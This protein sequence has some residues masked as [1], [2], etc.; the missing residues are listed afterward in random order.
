MILDG[1]YP[2]TVEYAG[3]IKATD[4]I[5]SLG[6][7]DPALTAAYQIGWAAWENVPSQV[8]VSKYLYTGGNMIFEDVTRP[9]NVDILLLSGTSTSLTPSFYYPSGLRYTSTWGTWYGPNLS[10]SLMRFINQ[11]DVNTMLYRSVFLLFLVGQNDA[12]SDVV[13]QYITPAQIAAGEV[14]FTL[15]YGGA[16]IPVTQDDI[17]G[18]LKIVE[19]DG[20]T[21]KFACIEFG[22]DSGERPI[23]PDGN[24]GNFYAPITSFMLHDTAGNSFLMGGARP[25]PLYGGD[26]S[27]AGYRLYADTGQLHY[28]SN[29][30]V[31]TDIGSNRYIWGGFRGTMPLQD[32]QDMP[33]YGM[34]YTEG[35]NFFVSCHGRKDVCMVRR[36][37]VWDDICKWASMQMRYG[38]T[39]AY[40]T[41]SDKYYAKISSDNEFLG[42]LAN[43]EI[44]FADLRPW[45]IAGVTLD[46]TSN[47]YTPDQKPPY[48]E[49]DDEK[50]GD[51]IG[52]NVNV[53]G[54][55]AT[56]LYTMYALRQAHVSNLGAAL[57]SS[58]NDPDG[59]FW[60]NL[61][62]AF[63]AYTET[64]SADISSV[65]EYITA[66]RIYPFAL[67][68]LPG[69]AG[70]GTGAIKIGSGKTDLNLSTGG[71]GNVGIMGSYTGI[72]DA[73]SVTIPAHYG[74]FRDYDGVSMSVY[75]PYIG[76]V[77]L[78]AA[79]V[80]GQTLQAT[81]AVD[82]TTGTAVCYLLLSGSWGYYPIGIYHGTIGAD[83]PLTAAQ[84]NRLFTRQLS[85][86]IS[87]I[88]GLAA[89][90]VIPD[91]VGAGISAISR[92]QS[93]ANA[94]TASALTPPT[95]G[96]G[97]ANFA[98][99]GAPQTAYVQ[100]RRHLYAYN[101]QTFPASQLGRRSYGVHTLGT[102]SGFTICDAVD[103]SGIPAPADIQTGIKNALESGVYL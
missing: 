28:N 98:G 27:G 76:N 100:I 26:I 21:Y 81:Y 44:D 61:Q 99:F 92:A 47:T 102:L 36:A 41:D 54:G 16:S 56:G 2:S 29:V 17:D 39:N 30:D 68:N 96:G 40:V 19:I 43:G 49:D 73:G 1:Q 42:V 89:G 9:E 82:L 45:Q 31:L 25:Y 48:G 20:N 83:I 3:Q 55:T 77:T 97:G 88:A 34:T 7:T 37:M 103:V 72:I 79:E 95:L 10:S 60:Q 91:T 50:I 90:R 93:A 67:V 69:F 38:T 46:A 33:V 78:D 63:G 35:C 75:L 6:I 12:N 5:V 64:G 94:L 52:F 14:S 57:W 70:A 8:H 84:G 86:A 22:I 24:V 59:N 66:L 74:D 58:L 32:V 13:V 62:M 11:V 65:L 85:G 51:S 4:T 15:S 80:T 87:K 23:R 53:P 18:S 101:A 71:A